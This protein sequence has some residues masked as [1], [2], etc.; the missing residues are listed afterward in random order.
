[1]N[2]KGEIPALIQ[3]IQIGFLEYNKQRFMIKDEENID[4][5]RHSLCYQLIKLILSH[6]THP[7]VNVFDNVAF[8]YVGLPMA[9]I[10][11][12]VNNYDYV[13]KNLKK[14][15]LFNLLFN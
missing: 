8:K 11:S 4:D 6:D 5:E 14:R 7:N 13:F 15:M 10:N 1:L 2:I 3:A 12:N 9:S